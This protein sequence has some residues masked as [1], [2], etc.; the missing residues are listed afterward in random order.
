MTWSESVDQALCFGWIDG[1][2]RTVDDERYTIRFTP[3]R[4]GS[5]WSTV[6]IAKME[7]LIKNGKVFPAGMAAYERRT[8]DRSS[9][10]SFEN[11]PLE[12]TPEMLREFQKDKKAWAFFESLAPSYKSTAIFHVMS[13]K[14]QA[15]RE[16]RFAKLMEESRAGRRI[17]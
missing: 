8:A 14:Q 15:T 16:R 1:V 11:A 6:N 10:Y 12:L 17:R 3:R 9:I 13:A 5:V 7:E 2:R 4:A